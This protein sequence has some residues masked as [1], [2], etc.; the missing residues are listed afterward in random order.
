MKK[1]TKI[2]LIVIAVLLVLLAGCVS[3][4]KGKYNSM[5]DLDEQVK[6]QWA[7]VENQYQRRYDLIP[8]LVATVKGYAAHESDVFTNIA[9]ARSKA[10]GVLQMSDELLEDEEAFAR[11]QKAQNELGSA[12]QR[13]LVVT[14]NYP[15]LKADENFLALQDQLEGTENRIATE[16]KRYN[17]VVSAYNKTVRQFPNVFFANMFGFRAK[18]YFTASE[19]AQSAP[20]VQF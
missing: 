15:E 5:V 19:S 8:N 6:T 17:D 11:F 10:G 9:N 12:L 20:V 3:S 2:T 4:I 16:R 14:E 18:A 7:Q 1:G 13:L